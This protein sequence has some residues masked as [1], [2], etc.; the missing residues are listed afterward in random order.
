MRRVRRVF[1]SPNQITTWPRV[2]GPPHAS[3]SRALAPS[4]AREFDAS[5]GPRTL[6]RRA[7]IAAI[8]IA[9]AATTSSGDVA[10]QDETC[11]P[12]DRLSTC[13]A[14]DNL[15][16][17]VGSRW[18][19]LGTTATTP[20]SSAAFGFVPTYYYRPIGLRIASPDP[21]GTTVYAVEHVLAASFLLAF[22]VGDRVELDLT[23][24]AILFQEG[25]S[26]S[27]VVGTTEELP[28]SAVGDIR[29]G[30]TVAIVRHRPRDEG[31][32]LSGRF[33][34]AMP[35][36]LV[37]AFSG[38]PSPTWAP[39]AT[40]DGRFGGFSFG[41]DA[42]A[43]LHDSAEL[44][45]AVIGNQIS[46]SLGV[47]YDFLDDDW[48]SLDLEAFALFGLE[49]QFVEVR[50]PGKF[51]ADEVESGDPHIPLEWLLSARTAGLLDGNLRV[52]LGGGSLIPTGTTTDV[53]APAFRTVLALH[54][55]YDFAPPAE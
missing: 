26:K 31:V 43:R 38:Y 19:S 51:E 5:R 8:V 1:D 41:I 25:S 44:A 16:P 13:I 29:F 24:P 46:V 6:G 4:G 47:A 23:A 7:A 49:K 22:G 20:E 54:Y 3:N 35:T 52:S 34:M 48:L 18:Q 27:D 36:G 40:F 55:V 30:T 2:K 42:G 45:G 17:H 39:G 14:S 28:R 11:A 32:G 12:R 53:T 9:L 33:E 50:S 37:G 15:W 10:A 21:A